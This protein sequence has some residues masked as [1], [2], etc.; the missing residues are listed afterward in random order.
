MERKEIIRGWEMKEKYED[1]GTFDGFERCMKCEYFD[2]KNIDC[3]YDGIC[4]DLE[5]KNDRKRIDK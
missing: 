2:K 3:T 1:Y 4:K 5:D